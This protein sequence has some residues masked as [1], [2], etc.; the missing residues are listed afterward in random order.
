MRKNLVK[1]MAALCMCAAFVSCSH[2][3]DFEA[4]NQE[5]TVE[6]LKNEYK[7]AFEQKYGEVAPNQSWD[8]TT[9]IGGSK[10]RTRGGQIVND[11][12]EFLGNNFFDYCQKD[13]KV[14]QKL[15]ETREDI[16][17][18]NQKFKYS[19]KNYYASGSATM[20]TWND[21]FS[22]KLYPSFACAKA[23]IKDDYW[24]LGFSYN[25][26]D[27]QDMIANIEVKGLGPY[28]KADHW[29]DAL[30]GTLEHATGRV[31]DTRPALGAQN[32]YWCAYTILD[33]TDEAT[34]A[35]N[36]A[37]MANLQ[38]KRI[39]DY[40]EIEVTRDGKTRTYWGF[41]CDQDGSYSDIICL[42]EDYIP[43]TPIVK[44]YLIEDLGS[45]G[46]FDFNDIVVD[47]KQEVNGTQTAT[48]RAMGGTLDFTL[49]I[50]NTSWTKRTDGALLDPKVEITDMV[51]T[52]FGEVD[53]SKS[54]ATFTVTGWR[55]DDNNI[56]VVVRDL[57][58]KEKTNIGTLE[59]TFPKEGD[60]PM[61]VACEE[62]VDWMYE[63]ESVPE[64]WYNPNA[65]RPTI[66]Q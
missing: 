35:A 26:S 32:V 19:G 41:D 4:S 39:T 50:G 65:P 25:N 56:T 55:P 45:I 29:Y 24:H 62:S 47:V 6:N 53:Y 43:P 46:D 14:I 38:A 64:W 57:Q 44:R 3:T 13:L 12:M 2:D 49:T 22:V 28:S 20:K 51:N 42:V 27:A 30:S 60:V 11:E 18:T 66:E 63:Q 61:I 1:G 5:F 31:I 21:Y 8:F 23:S 59:I 16:S 37:T 33:G 15:F 36:N 17:F 48:I 34:V 9:K 52:K 10:V 7:A 40:R 58:L 54:I